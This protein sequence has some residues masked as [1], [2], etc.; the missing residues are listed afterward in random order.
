M[1]WRREG[2]SAVHPKNEPALTIKGAGYLKVRNKLASPGHPVRSPRS[3]TW[4]KLAAAPVSRQQK[5]AMSVHF[6]PAQK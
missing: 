6:I 1:C 5:P 3:G 2:R 4:S